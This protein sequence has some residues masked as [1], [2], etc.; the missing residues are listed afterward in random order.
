MPDKT[1]CL[2]FRVLKFMALIFLFEIPWIKLAAGYWHFWSCELWLFSVARKRHFPVLKAALICAC[3]A[4]F[5]QGA[6]MMRTDMTIS[7]TIPMMDGAERILTVINGKRWLRTL[8]QEL[9][10]PSL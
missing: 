5:E 3:E 10:E 2:S 8:K 1:I 7:A 4:L 9:S 6:M